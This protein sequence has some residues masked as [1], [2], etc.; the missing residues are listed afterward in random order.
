MPKCIAAGI[1]R[2]GNKAPGW[3][4]SS[5][6]SGARAAE[7]VSVLKPEREIAQRQHAQRR[8]SKGKQ[9]VQYAPGSKCIAK[10]KWGGAPSEFG[11]MTS[12]A[13]AAKKGFVE[14]MPSILYNT[15]DGKTVGSQTERIGVL[16]RATPRVVLGDQGDCGP[17]PDS[18]RRLLFGHTR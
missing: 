1:V 16:P 2:S 14:G 9:Q 15:D 11:E 18:R 8:R 12:A 5:A 3:A 7:T 17:V 6:K 4:A 10:A 13:S